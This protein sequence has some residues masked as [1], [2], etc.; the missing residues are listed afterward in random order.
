MTR[1]FVSIIALIVNLNF[2]YAQTSLVI[3]SLL[4][5]YARENDEIKKVNLLYEIGRTYELNDFDKAGEFYKKALN[6]SKEIKYKVGEIMYSTHY[7]YILNQQAKYDSSLILNLYSVELSREIN[8]SLYIAKTLFNTGTVYREKGDFENAVAF[9]EEG[10]LFF[11]NFK[12][13]QLNARI[14][15]V[16]SILYNEMRQFDKAL[17]YGQTALELIN[18]TD[19][20]YFKMD[21]LI[22]ISNVYFNKNN[23]KKAFQSLN[24]ALKIAG[25]L[26]DYT[27]LSTIYLNIGNIYLSQKDFEPFKKCMENAILY[28]DKLD[29]AENKLIASKGLS[30]YYLNRKQ[31]DKAEEYALSALDQNKRVNNYIQLQKVYDLLSNIYYAKHDILKADFYSG[32]SVQLADSIL[33]ETIIEKTSELQTKY[34]VHKKEEQIIIQKSLLEKRRIINIVLIISLLGMLLTVLIYS[35]YHKQ[36]QIIQQQRIN[37]LET[38]KKLN[39]TALVLKGEEQERLRLAKDLHDGLGG[40]LSGIKFSLNNMK[41]NLIMTADNAHAFE[42]SIDMLDSSIKEMRRVAHNMM[43]EALVKFGLDVALKDFCS[44]INQSGIMKINYQSY[45]MEQKEIEQTKSI[46]IYRIVQELINNAL[47]HSGAK[48]M[49]VQLSLSEGNLAVTVE[50]D[51]R[52]FDKSILDKA[53]GMGWGNIKNRVEFLKGH[54]DLNSNIGVGTSILIE[55]NI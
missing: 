6:L 35:R 48:E 19:N 15:D 14:H 32:K 22:N 44:D 38:E 51:G 37:Q 26:N 2:V 27:A 47:K 46:A 55:I 43:P 53:G 30:L 25:D 45:G 36:K 16:L 54:I 28:A 39:A 33:N 23:F 18:K 50:D 11:Q 12:D 10:I 9:Y 8:D 34:Q 41:G 20:S 24:E 3:D 13:D 42:R 7:T 17:K 49:L 40:M 29:L 4:K 5:A 31:F 52:G 1:I 21:I